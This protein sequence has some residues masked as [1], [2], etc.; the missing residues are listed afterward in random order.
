MHGLALGT[1]IPDPYTSQ[2]TKKQIFMLRTDCFIFT[3]GNLLPLV[4]L[5]T[6]VGIDTR[7]PPSLA[8]I[9]KAGNRC[10]VVGYGGAMSRMMNSWNCGLQRI[11]MVERYLNLIPLRSAFFASHG[12]TFRS[13]T[14]RY[15]LDTGIRPCGLLCKAF[16]T[17]TT[18]AMKGVRLK[19]FDGS[20]DRVDR[21]S[22]QG[23]I[24][25]RMI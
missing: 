1:V 7:T 14:D 19:L 23:V 3:E 8:N 5:T 22:A 12:D 15:P 4:G 24:N 20:P 21:D 6:D 9:P 11:E 2:D 17:L 25:N 13:W 16:N 18:D 10:Y